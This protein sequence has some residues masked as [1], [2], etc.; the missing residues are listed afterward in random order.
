MRF[1]GWPAVPELTVAID[2]LASIT[3]ATWSPV[4]SR[5]LVAGRASASPRPRSAIA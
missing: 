3:I 4:I 5:P 2:A 1:T